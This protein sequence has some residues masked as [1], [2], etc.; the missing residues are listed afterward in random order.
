VTR[1]HLINDRACWDP[2]SSFSTDAQG[3]ACACGQS[4]TFE[5]LALHI[6]TENSAPERS[7]GTV[8]DS[9]DVN[10]DTAAHYLPVEPRSPAPAA[11]VEDQPTRPELPLLRLPVN[12]CPTCQIGAQVADLPEVV[13]W[14]C[15]HWTRTKP[16]PV[17]ESFQDMLRTT[18]QAGVAAATSGETFETWY[19]REVLQ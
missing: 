16:Q 12:A 18:F 8:R 10:R 13:A 9:S 14:S 7:S 11:P 1:H 2:L 6:A 5:A 19:Q 4:G 17:A 3:H 15:G